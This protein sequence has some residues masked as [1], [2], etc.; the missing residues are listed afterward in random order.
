MK[1]SE[2]RQIIKEEISKVLKENEEQGYTLYTS[3]VEYDNGKT[4][5]MYQLVNSEDREEN[6]IGFDQLYFDDEDNR[7]EMGVDFKD[8][9]QGSYQEEEVSA[10]EAMKIYNEL[11]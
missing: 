1:K 8:F 5:Y 6:E 9:D 11:K 4:G 10:E 2:L 7:L 3:N